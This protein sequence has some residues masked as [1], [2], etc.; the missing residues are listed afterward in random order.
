[1]RL[2]LKHKRTPWISRIIL[3]ATIAYLVS[4]IDLIPD[5]IP[6]LG[7]LDDAVIVPAMYKLAMWFIPKEVIA[8]CRDKIFPAES[9]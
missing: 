6:V 3:A 1:M 4:P 5:W 8:E 7:Q 9:K 2:I